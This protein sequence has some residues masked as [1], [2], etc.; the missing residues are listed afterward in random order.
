[1]R[2]TVLFTAMT[3]FLA[4]NSTIAAGD[5]PGG[6]LAG[7]VK[8]AYYFDSRDFNTLAV[9]LSVKNL[10]FGWNLWGF[11]DLHGRQH[12]ARGRFHISRT[13]S[14]YRLS[15]NLARLSGIDGLG[16]QFEYNHF[17]PANR[18]VGLAFRF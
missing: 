11:T 5:V 14:E 12:D 2:L 1:M 6:K 8:L 3:V 13:F 9:N 15:K 17:T 18:S 7:T 16:F 10:P 4:G